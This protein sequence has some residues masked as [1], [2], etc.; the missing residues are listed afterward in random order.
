[1][2][3]P[4]TATLLDLSGRVAIVTGAGAGIGAGIAERFA[5]AGAA[6]VVHY[7][8]NEAGAGDVVARIAS[9]DGRA[10]ACRADLTSSSGAEGLIEFASRELDLPAVLINNAGVYPVASILDMPDRDWRAVIDATL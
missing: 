3:V 6:V 9:R 8:T 7:R 5:S 1:M 4:A 2:T 10:L